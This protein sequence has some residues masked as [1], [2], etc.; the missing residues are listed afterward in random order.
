MVPVHEFRVG[1]MPTEIA[2]AAELIA[3]VGPARP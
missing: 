3:S 1:T 2:T